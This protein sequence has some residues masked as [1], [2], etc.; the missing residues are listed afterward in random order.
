EP[1]LQGKTRWRMAGLLVIILLGAAF[2]LGIVF[3]KA[4]LE[5]S[6]LV[7]DADYP[8]GTKIANIEWRPEFTELEVWVTNSSDKNYDDLSLLIRPTFPIVAISQLT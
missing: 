5:I 4:P 7:T 2:S 8:R 6:T 3:V 1:D